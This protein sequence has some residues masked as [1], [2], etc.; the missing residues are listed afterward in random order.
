LASGNGFPTDSFRGVV[1]VVTDPGT[2]TCAPKTNA[3]AAFFACNGNY[4]PKAGIFYNGATLDNGPS[5]F[6]LRHTFEAHGLVNLPW[7]IQLSN[8]FRAQSGFR[9]TAVAVVPLDQDGNGNFDGRDLKTGRNV[10]T[11]PLF[12]NMDMRFARTWTIRE[13]YRVEGLFE[14]FNLF[15]NSNA[16][17]IQN[18]QAQAATFGTVSQRL[19]GREGQVGLKIEF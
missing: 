16:A 6:A 2:A 9:Y 17:A 11:A 18:Q 8:I 3:S 5:D 13:R 14:F 4:V 19:P 10:F 12:V 15:N 1:P 7:K